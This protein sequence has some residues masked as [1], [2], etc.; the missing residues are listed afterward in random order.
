MLNV[1]KRQLV[2]LPQQIRNLNRQPLTLVVEPWADEF[3]LAPDEV[4]EIVLV[5]PRMGQP[6]VCP[7]PHRLTINGWDGS[8]FVAL[9]EGRLA[10]PPPSVSDVVRQEF[11][12]AERSIRRTASNWPTEDI[13]IIDQKM[14]FFSETATESQE[15]A[16]NLASQLVCKLAESVED[17]DEAATLL[18]QIADRVVGHDGV[19]LAAPGRQRRRQIRSALWEDRSDELFEII[20]NCAVSA[21]HGP[22]DLAAATRGRA[23]WVRQRPAESESGPTVP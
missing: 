17:S 3:E 1:P 13:E 2:R 5:G 19:L 20:W 11:Q 9:K 6:E 15:F 14:D 16:C 4:I 23:Q 21:Y 10:T 12:I 18:W 8:E 7:Y 22:F